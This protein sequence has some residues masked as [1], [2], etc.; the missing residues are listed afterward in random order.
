M[1]EVEIIWNM[2]L[3]HEART[4]CSECPTRDM[5]VFTKSSCCRDNFVSAVCCMRFILFESVRHDFK[6]RNVCTVL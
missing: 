5:P 3:G 1:F 2:L 6:C 4:R